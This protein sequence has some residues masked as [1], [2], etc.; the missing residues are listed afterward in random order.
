MRNPWLDLPTD[1]PPYCLPEDL[2]IISE[3]NKQVEEKH[4]IRIDGLPE[5]YIGSTRDPRV[6]LLNLNPGWSP[7]DHKHFV[8]PDFRNAVL[9]NLHNTLEEYPFYHLNP[10]FHFTGGAKWWSQKLRYLINE[11]GRETV[12]NHVI[13]LE[14]FPYPSLRYKAVSNRIKKK[15]GIQLLQ[16]QKYTIYLL[17]KF[18]NLKNT[19]FVGMRSIKK[20]M[21]IVPELE[22]KIITVK[23]FQNPVISPRNLPND[24]S[25][26]IEVLKLQEGHIEPI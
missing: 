25:R 3:F 26:L 6:V 20:W 22:G 18:L 9:E 8:L 13:V 10:K 7:E 5:A 12:A 4:L 19:I 2:P 17:K 15:F 1:K 11:V 24:F 21:E 16:G 23:N 14:Y